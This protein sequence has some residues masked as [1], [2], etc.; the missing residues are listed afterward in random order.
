MRK[1]R[2]KKRNLFELC[3]QILQ[4][5]YVIL[6]GFHWELKGE[7]L[8]ENFSILLVMG[9]RGQVQPHL[10]HFVLRGMRQT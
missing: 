4:R 10:E 1:K 3:P 5:F 6:V 7:I 2:N 9:Y 8:K